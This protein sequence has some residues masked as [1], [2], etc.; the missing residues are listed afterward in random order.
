ME[1]KI[2]I[3]IPTFERVEWTLRAFEQVLYDDRV[4]EVVIVD[5]CSYIDDYARLLDCV[6][7]MDKVH[8]S[9]NDKNLGCYLNKRLAIELASNPWV[10][11]LDSDNIID[12]SYLDIIFSQYWDE[13]KIMAPQFGR[14]SLDYSQFKDVVVWAK[15][16]SGFM[17]IGNFEMFLNTFNFVVNR[18]QFLKVFDDSVEPWTSDSIYFCYCWLKSENYIHCVPELSYTHTIHAQSHY[19]THNQKAPGFH[20]SVLEKLKQL[21]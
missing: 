13:K 2:S 11:I 16:V 18:E 21:R 14:P 10:I 5:D 9:R 17:N 8:L 1:R 15:N 12:A 19:V 6:E 20:E 7:G 3:C 4:G